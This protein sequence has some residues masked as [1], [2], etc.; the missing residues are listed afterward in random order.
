MQDNWKNNIKDLMAER[1]ISPHEDSWAKLEKQL[2][3]EE[4]K[5]KLKW[6]YFSGVAVCLIFMMAGFF[7]FSSS[8][9]TIKTVSNKTNSKVQVI[10]SEPLIID[11]PELNREDLVNEN[12]QQEKIISKPKKEEIK[13][14]A[15]NQIDV[16]EKQF[17]PKIKSDL[18]IPETV[19]PKDTNQIKL[20]NEKYVSAEDLL[21]SI[22]SEINT[23]KA[24]GITINEEELLAK[25]EDEIF[26]DKSTKVFDKIKNEVKRILALNDRIIN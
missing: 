15:S 23:A 26:D 22:E 10:H 4:E 19:L 8:Q 13:A 18:M 1:R 16:E 3:V 5:P 24:K 2:S 21:A 25:V 14:I 17:E 12:N 7:Y 11:I 6:W 20:K 9:N